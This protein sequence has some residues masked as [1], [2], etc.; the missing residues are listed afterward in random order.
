LKVLVVVTEKAVSNVVKKD[1]CL[2]IA[3]KEDQD[4]EERAVSNVVKK[5]TCLEIALKEDQEAVEHASNV[6]KKDTCLGN[7]QVLSV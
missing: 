1:T 5:D 6:V 7:V 3:P 4:Q 2:E